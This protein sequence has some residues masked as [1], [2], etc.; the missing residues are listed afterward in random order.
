M[1]ACR[2]ARRQITV[3]IAHRLHRLQ[4]AAPHEHGRPAVQ[5][6]F[7]AIEEIL[8]RRQ[9]L[10]LG[11]VRGIGSAPFVCRRGCAVRIY[12]RYGARIVCL[13]R[14]PPLIA[15]HHVLR[16]RAVVR[17]AAAMFQADVA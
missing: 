4:R 10:V 6:L 9:L 11:F 15:A 3:R 17:R 13:R 7:A 2:H 12:V 1:E 8:P 5:P 16:C 14:V